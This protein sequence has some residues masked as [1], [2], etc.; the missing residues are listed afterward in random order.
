VQAKATREVELIAASKTQLGEDTLT[1]NKSSQKE[2]T[3]LVT[4]DTPT[5]TT[6][7]PLKRSVTPEWPK[8][9]KKAKASKT[10]NEVTILIEGDPND[11]K[12]VVH[13]DTHD[14]IDK[15]MSE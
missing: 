1:N 7:A 2:T 11:I 9:W 14:G 12:N 5:T 3:Q 13:E 4:T 15:A 10:D 6:G 8:P